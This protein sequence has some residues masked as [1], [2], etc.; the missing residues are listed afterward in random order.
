[1]AV[2]IL[3]VKLPHLRKSYQKDSGD[4]LV[5]RNDVG[6]RQRNGLPLHVASPALGVLANVHAQH[7]APLPSCRLDKVSIAP[8]K[9]GRD[10]GFENSWPKSDLH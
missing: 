5:T 6:K 4:I 1:M 7:S 3:T 2:V 9:Q 8:G 10:F